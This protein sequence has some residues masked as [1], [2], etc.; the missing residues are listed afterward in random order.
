MKPFCFLLLIVFLL[1]FGSA[2]QGPVCDT[3]QALKK[4][5]YGFVVP[6]LKASEREARMARLDSFWNVARRA[7]EAAAQ[8]IA[9]MI[10]AETND[11]YFCYDAAGLLQG[12]DTGTRYRE[13][14]LEGLSKADLRGLNLEPFLQLTLYLA[15]RGGDIRAP[16]RRFLELPGNTVF[17]R[18]HFATLSG[19]DASVFL[20]NTMPEGEQEIFLSDLVRNGTGPARHCSAVLLNLLATPGGDSVL[21]AAWPQ[22]ADSTRRFIQKDRKDFQLPARGTASRATVLQALADV[23]YNLEKEFFGF[24]GN[25]NLIGSACLRLQPAD[26][27]QVRAARRRSTPGLSD[28]GLHEYFALTGILMTVRAKNRAG[29]NSATK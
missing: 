17:L 19:I 13:A 12:L 14:V 1:P 16:L 29:K 25:S 27:E 26:L 4:E 20:L 22:L 9:T 2:A 21:Q 23:P 6:A 28:E 11:G 3:L 15:N 8:C 10:H 5:V 7:P 18:D 24:A